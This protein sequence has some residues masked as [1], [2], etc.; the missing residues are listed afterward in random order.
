MIPMFFFPF[1]TVG[2]ALNSLAAVSMEDILGGMFQLRIPDS[3][4]ALV[5]Q[6]LSVFFGVLSFILVFIVEQL[7]SVLQVRYYLLV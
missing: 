1:R 3:K 7:G 4:G 6:W 5:S 2:A